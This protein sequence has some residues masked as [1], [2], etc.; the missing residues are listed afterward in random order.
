[1]R[2]RNA[3][4]ITCL[5]AALS[6]GLGSALGQD[7]YDVQAAATARQRFI[8][9]MVASH[10]F[11]RDDLVALLG[12]ARVDPAILETIARPAERVVPWY[13]YRNIF[14]TERRIADGA[15]FWQS[16]APSIER[17][18]MRYSVAPEVLVAIIGVETF[19][20]QRMGS[21][22][23]IDALATLAF[24]YP[25]RSEFFAREL[26]AFLLLHREEGYSLA[27]AQ[28]SYAGAMGAGQ[29]IPSSYRAYAVDGNG[30]GRRD[31][32]SDWDDILASVANYLARH[33]WRG[34]EPV[35]VAARRGPSATDEPSNRLE[36][37][38]SVGA[39]HTAGYEFESSLPSAA[40][41][42]AFS[43][44]SGPSS[45]EYWVGF[46][47]FWVI[48]RYNRSTKYALAVHELAE[49]ITREFNSRGIPQ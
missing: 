39:L 43:F 21:H 42:A 19:Y 40:K 45:T 14:L 13:D 1:M 31:L 3:R 15:S 46:N 35:A 30:D 37:D 4:R 20:G 17:T 32:W 16:H 36:L 12:G 8:E 10:G 33:G 24:A 7:G 11:D 28:G 27:E 18:A 48:T 38:A 29:F 26:E 2:D 49:A 5:I 23:V 34:G 6:C 9:R 44:E 41:A 25:P 22:R 47:N